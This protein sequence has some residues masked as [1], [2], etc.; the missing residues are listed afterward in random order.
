[1]YLVGVFDC[2]A[3]RLQGAK[4]RAA[5]E[6]LIFFFFLPTIFLKARKKKSS[7]N[8]MNPSIAHL[9]NTA[10]FPVEY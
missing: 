10:A 6:S 9:A 3:T 7:M 8:R 2:G 1:V 5:P 4:V